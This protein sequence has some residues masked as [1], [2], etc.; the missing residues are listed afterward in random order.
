MW[1]ASSPPATLPTRSTNKPSP[2]P[3]WGAK[4]RS[5]LNAGSPK[6]GSTR[7]YRENLSMGRFVVGILALVLL[8]GL[9]AS[10]ATTTT[11]PTTRPALPPMPIPSEP[12]DKPAPRMG[13]DGKVSD[14]FMKMHIMFL[15]Q[16][17]LG[18]VN[19]LFMGDVLTDNWRK[20]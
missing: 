2:P 5:T 13:R 3:A 8:I 1:K 9:W 17:K 10:A 6:K 18:G 19:L 12:A 20:P 7:V 11:S 15:E 4:R 16:G 14:Y